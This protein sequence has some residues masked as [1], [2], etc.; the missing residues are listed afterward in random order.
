MFFAIGIDVEVDVGS[1]RERDA[2]ICDR[3]AGIELRR[4]LERFDGRLMIETVQ[5]RHPLIEISL[6]LRIF[7]A[8]SKM[9]FAEAWFDRGDDEERQNHEELLSF[10]CAN[11]NRRSMGNP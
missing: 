7:R 11:L 2:P 4:L 8:D 10:F 5:I 1:E 3:E 6:R 9:R